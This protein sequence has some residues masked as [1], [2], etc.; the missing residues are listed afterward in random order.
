MGTPIIQMEFLIFEGKKNHYIIEEKLGVYACSK[1]QMTE[2]KI[3]G[4]GKR[5]DNF[6]EQYGQRHTYLVKDFIPNF[7][8]YILIVLKIENAQGKLCSSSC[9]ALSKYYRYN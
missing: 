4:K 9:F 3:L 8:P 6:F 1:S 2:S 7:K 5:L